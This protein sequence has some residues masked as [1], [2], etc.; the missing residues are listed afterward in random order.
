MYKCPACN[1]DFSDTEAKGHGFLCPDC[2]VRLQEVAGP[3]KGLGTRV[4]ARKGE[5]TLKGMIGHGGEANVWEAVDGDGHLWVVKF[6]DKEGLTDRVEIYSKINGL[7]NVIGLEDW[8]EHWDEGFVVFPYFSQGKIRPE[9]FR[10]AGG[11]LDWDKL[12]Q[13]VMDMASA[14]SGVHVNGV[15]HR[16]LKPDNI[17]VDDTGNFVLGDFGIATVHSVTTVALTVS[18]SPPELVSLV[19][20]VRK[21][22]GEMTKK[23]DWW[24]IGV[25]LLEL[26]DRHPFAQEPNPVSAI[27]NFPRDIYI[28]G[29]NIP[30]RWKLLLRGLLT[31]NPLLRWGDDQVK[32]WIGDG[33]PMVGPDVAEFLSLDFGGVIYYSIQDLAA[34]AW[35]DWDLAMKDLVE[36][37]E[38]FTLFGYVQK[39]V[40]TR[41]TKIWNNNSLSNA[42]KIAFVLWTLNPGLCFGFQG[43]RFETRTELLE[44]LQSDSQQDQEFL[45]VLYKNRLFSRYFSITGDKNPYGQEVGQAIK[46]IQKLEA[47]NAAPMVMALAIDPVFA[48]QWTKECKQEIVRVKAQTDKYIATNEDASTYLNNLEA[49]KGLLSQ[50]RPHETAWYTKVWGL[51]NGLKELPGGF[52][53]KEAFAKK[54]RAFLGDMEDLDLGYGAEPMQYIKFGIL[55]GTLRTEMAHGWIDYDTF[56]HFLEILELGSG[57]RSSAPHRIHT[58]DG[59]LQRENIFR[60]WQII[61]PERP[62]IELNPIIFQAFSR[63]YVHFALWIVD[64]IGADIR[65]VDD[66]GN[67][68][69]HYAAKGKSRYKSI[70]EL[71]K[72]GVKV[73]S[74]NRKGETPLYIAATNGYEDTVEVL[75]EHGADVNAKDKD[76]KTALYR[77]ATDK[78]HSVDRT[79][80][81]MVRHLLK[82]GADPNT[83]DKIDQTPLHRLASRT[84]EWYDIARLLVEHG[85][86]VNAKDR[87]GKTP[88]DYIPSNSNIRVLLERHGAKHGRDLR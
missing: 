78:S 35:H 84:R 46:T 65:M 60:A 11:V 8:G 9:M 41:F 59:A 69:M 63:N 81:E 87:W 52:V 28:N 66:Q 88:L 5:Y 12:E 33:T 51:C 7:Y 77:V 6:V 2:G 43:R 26:I 72:K 79:R 82:K 17:L 56:K 83:K 71:V 13:L 85:A 27:R 67:G 49:L 57:L 86:D 4:R 40:R 61:D 16:D 3:G 76:G 23:I 20:D 36:D 38:I 1:R 70:A 18:Y 44:F 31:K 15:V 14:I 53:D 55:L 47:N 24:S 73:D 22:A 10:K 62:K 45:E 75:I 54:L 42:Q 68:L 48:G 74:K 29:L 39:D 58:V 19:A 37:G 21:T 80:V 34:A 64:K 25:T 50:S 30:D 32:S